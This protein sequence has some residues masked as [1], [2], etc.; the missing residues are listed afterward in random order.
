[1]EVNLNRVQV[2]IQVPFVKSLLR[3]NDNSEK[4]ILQ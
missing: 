4:Y 2:I 3:F 1:M